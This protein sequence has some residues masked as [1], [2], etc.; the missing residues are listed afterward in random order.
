MT[1]IIAYQ[2]DGKPGLLSITQTAKPLQSASPVAFTA[3]AQ[4]AKLRQI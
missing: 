2:S 3:F 4:C 1:Q